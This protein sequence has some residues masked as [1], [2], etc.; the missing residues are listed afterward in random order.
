MTK[1]LKVSLFSKRLKI[2]LFVKKKKK[3]EKNKKRRKDFS[4]SALPR[5]SKHNT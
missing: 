3:K 4:P 1:K 5:D 2:R